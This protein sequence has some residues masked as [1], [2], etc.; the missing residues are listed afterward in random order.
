MMVKSMAKK[1]LKK[2]LK[3][4][5]TKRTES[6]YYKKIKSDFVDS[7]IKV[8]KENIKPQVEYLVNQAALQAPKTLDSIRRDRIE[9]GFYSEWEVVIQTFEVVSENGNVESVSSY[10]A[11]AVDEFNKKEFNRQFLHVVGV[12]P[13]SFEPYI[14]EQLENFVRTNVSLIQNIGSDYLKKIETSVLNGIQEGRLGRDISET[15]KKTISRINASEK[16]IR[17][18]AKLIARDQVSKFNG[19]LNQLRQTNV[20]VTAYTWQT[21]GDE[22]DERVRDSHARNDG[23]TFK[24]SD[25]PSTGHPGDEFQCRC[26]AIP[27]FSEILEK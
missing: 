10:G 11:T 4:K 2:P 22:G 27:N 25:P 26:V 19:N 15:V 14:A 8:V 9:D 17:N 12:Q 24:W 21:S 18:R 7:L 13:F 3:G 16:Q 1:R 20:G 5:T 6:L 23:K